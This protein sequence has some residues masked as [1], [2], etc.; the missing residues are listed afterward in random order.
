MHRPIFN[1]GYNHRPDVIIIENNYNCNSGGGFGNI[2]SG[3]GS[4]LMGVC[5]GLSLASLFTGGGAGYSGGYSMGPSMGFPV[6]GNMGYSRGAIN[7]PIFN[8]M[9]TLMPTQA[10]TEMPGATTP[11][12]YD[13][14]TQ[15]VASLTNNFMQNMGSPAADAP[16]PVQPVDPK[17][18]GAK[19][20]AWAIENSIKI[21]QAAKESPT[22]GD[23]VI[24]KMSDF[25]FAGEAG[26]QI[27]PEDYKAGLMKLSQDTIKSADKNGDSVL[28]YE[29]FRD[30]E[31]ADYKRIKQ[32]ETIDAGELQQLDEKTKLAFTTI[33]R[34][35]K[36]IDAKDEAAVY[37]YMDTFSDGEF[38]GKIGIKSFN[39]LN[40]KLTDSGQQEDAKK[41]LGDLYNQFFS[42]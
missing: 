13:Y 8:Q 2:F 5:A 19:F 35:G 24:S 18:E 20:D 22:K 17:N 28:S 21:N 3:L 30:K 36:G 33:S 23:E 1:G 10:P 6:G 14:Q 12:A 34:D 42:A 9:P 39:G 25:R 40:S 16:A 7:Q 4:T 38:N 37:A 32:T 31:L 15:Q 41:K 26:K 29:E 11:D 27:K